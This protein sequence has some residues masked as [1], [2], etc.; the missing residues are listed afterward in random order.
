M[1][2]FILIKVTNNIKRFIDK[3][4][5]YE[6]DLHNVTYIDENKIIV[7]INKKD[8]EFIKKYN[9]YSEIE[10]YSKL[11]IDSIKE[12]IFNQKYFILLFIFCLIGMYFISNFI[13]KINVIHS[14]K[15]IRELVREELNEYGISKYSY[16]KDFKELNK[17]KNKI[18][19]DKKDKLEWISITNIGMTYVV[20][21]EERIIDEIKTKNEYCNVYAN[22]E[23]LIT[24]I[25]STAGE[26]IV[27]V[28][29]IIKPNDLLISGT[30]LLNEETKGYTCANGKIMGK[31]WYTTNISLEREYY[32]KE[33]TGKSRL[34]FSI[35]KKV[36]RNNKY[37]K[38]DKKYFIKTKFFTLYKELEYKN[39]KYK[40]NNKESL[41]QALYEVDNKFKIKLGDNGKVL[42]K[43]IL[44]KEI[45]DKSINLSVFVTTEENIAKQKVLSIP[46]LDKIKKD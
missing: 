17:I 5:K 14:N 3:C 41:E 10:T 26:I 38:F 20:R 34:N 6:I 43:K 9:Y 37:T 39:K 40:Y 11:G 21:I 7:K 27:S 4:K 44:N 15:K 36:L 2:K 31:V 23:A 30:I 32:K 8:L 19:E 45:T 12:K 22:K 25:Y 24:N 16:K 13:L 35:N 28:N 1:N 42:S 33:Y 29:D 46:N 18:L